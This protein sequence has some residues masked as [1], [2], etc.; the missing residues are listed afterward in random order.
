MNSE[1][2]WA[3]QNVGPWGLDMWWCFVRGN[4]M[5]LHGQ[6]PQSQG[7]SQISG[8]RVFELAGLRWAYQGL[9]S[10]RTECVSVCV[11]SGRSGPAACSTAHLHTRMAHQDCQSFVRAQCKSANGHSYFVMWNFEIYSLYLNERFFFSCALDACIKAWFIFVRL[12]LYNLC[13]L[14][15]K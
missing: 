8:I 2:T 3:P 5:Y 15:E 13:C 6:I 12:K 9:G 7:L 14:Q 1:G 11:A 10:L 4:G